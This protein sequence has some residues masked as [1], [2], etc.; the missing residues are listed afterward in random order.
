M[1]MGR[2]DEAFAATQQM[3]DLKPNLPS[4]SRASYAQWLRGDARA[5]KESVRLAIDSGNDGR[6][7]EPRSW[8]IVQAAMLFWHAGDY[9]GAEAGF[10]HALAWNP[11]F[12]PALVGKGKVAMAKGDAKTAVDVLSRAFAQSPLVETAWLLGDAKAMAGDSAGARVAYD[13]VENEGKKSDPRTLSAFLS[14]RN[15]KPELA[16]ALAEKEHQVRQDV[17]TDDVLAWALYRNGRIA[18]AKDAIVRARRLGTNDAR[19]AYHEGAIR[20]ANGEI[21]EG[22]ALVRKALST[23]PKFDVAGAAEAQSVANKIAG[24]SVVPKGTHG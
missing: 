10:D 20:I 8:V 22:S 17:Y 16:L 23:C 11:E 6:D 1:E 9:A 18:E 14:A 15:E 19:L 3:I 24:Q 13:F 7:R 5:A 21:A 2:Y 12:P 4:Y